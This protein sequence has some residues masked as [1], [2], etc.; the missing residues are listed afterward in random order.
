MVVKVSKKIKIQ[1]KRASSEVLI[2]RIFENTFLEIRINAL[3]KT[4][5]PKS[6]ITPPAI[7]NVADRKSVV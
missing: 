5:I 3:N 1:K 2:F 4:I 6:A 7:T